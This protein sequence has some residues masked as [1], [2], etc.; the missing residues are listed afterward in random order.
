MLF[1]GNP[2]Y[3]NWWINKISNVENEKFN[4]KNNILFAYNSDFGLIPKEQEKVFE[5]DLYFFMKTLQI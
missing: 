4:H 5:Q 2:A 3:D 1:Y